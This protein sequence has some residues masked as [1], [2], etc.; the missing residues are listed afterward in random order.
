MKLRQ[1]P[2]D[3][4]VVEESAVEPR[5]QGSFGLYRLVKTGIPTLE[6]LAIVAREMR[7]P[8]SRVTVG[9]LKDAHAVTEQA[10]AI[11]AGPAR[12]LRHPAFDL[13][14]LGRTDGPLGREAVRGNRFRIAIRDLSREEAALVGPRLAAAARDGVPNYFDEQR[15]GSARATGEFP[16][17]LLV[18][19]DPEGALRLLIGTPGPEDRSQRKRLRAT[20]GRLWGDWEGALRELPRSSERSIVAFLKDHPRDFGGAVDRLESDFRH[21]ALSAYQSLVWDRIL[22]ALLSR[23]LGATARPVETR[24]VRLVFWEEAPATV[25]DE[26]RAL[27]IPLPRHDAE[28][29]GELREI[30][31]EVLGSDGVTVEG[32]R[33]RGLRETEFRPGQRPAVVVPEEATAEAPVTDEL[34]AGRQAASVAFRLPSGSYAT[35]VVKRLALGF[36]GGGG[37]R[38]DRVR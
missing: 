9:G 34:N 13:R 7:V 31:S 15:F 24:Y 26:L 25:L 11:A 29:A 21:L 36:R 10:V 35:I 22:V 38:A 17:R 8:R 5:E 4:Q 16:G 37:R 33:A 12:D 32:F 19:G 20:L 28:Y 1:R 30:A 2:A 18:T 6:A 3:F 27:K 23:R 14:Y